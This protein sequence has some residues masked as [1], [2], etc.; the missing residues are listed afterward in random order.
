MKLKL[1]TLLLAI[2]ASVGSYNY[3]RY[4]PYFGGIQFSDL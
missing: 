3:Y 4:Y 2:A 1:F